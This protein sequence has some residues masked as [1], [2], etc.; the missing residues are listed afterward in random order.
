MRG[1]ASPY[2]ARSA[3]FSST[4]RVCSMDAMLVARL[5]ASVASASAASGS[6]S[7]QP[8]SFLTS[9]LDWP[10]LV[11]RSSFTWPDSTVNTFSFCVVPGAGLFESTK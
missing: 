6:V 11:S 9:V 5:E 3:A 2:G 10:A 4:T 7:C 8:A 1:S